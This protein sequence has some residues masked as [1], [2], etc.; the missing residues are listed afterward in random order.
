MFNSGVYETVVIKISKT[1]EEDVR[2]RLIFRKLYLF[3][4]EKNVAMDVSLGMFQNF[5][6]NFFPGVVWTAA[7]VFLSVYLFYSSTKNLIYWQ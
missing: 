7:S 1:S 3:F 6:H 5:H 2:G 4:S